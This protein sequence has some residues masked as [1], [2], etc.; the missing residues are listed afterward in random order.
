MPKSKTAKA[1]RPN[2]LLAPLQWVPERLGEAIDTDPSLVRPLLDI[3]RARMHL[4][5]LAL[6]HLTGD[7]SP[8]LARLFLTG[9]NKEI[10]DCCLANYPPGLGRVLG[11]L[12]AKVIAAHSYRWLVDLL[13]DPATRKC[14]HHLPSIDETTI[15]AVHRLPTALRQPA[16][17]AM[18]GQ[19][20]GMARFVDGLTFLAA[21][22]RFPVDS[23]LNDIGTLQQP[24]Q[25][26]AKVRRLVEALPLPNP[27]LPNQIGRF[28]RL[29]SIAEIRGLAK[30]WRNCLEDC[31]AQ[32]NEN[33]AAVYLS[34]QDQVVCLVIRYGR[35]GWAISQVK[36]PKN[37]DVNSDLLAQIY[38]AFSGAGIVAVEDIEAIRWI[39]WTRG[40]HD[41]PLRDMDVEEAFLADPIL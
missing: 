36:G 14:L 17:M 3:S 13:A 34:D 5:A 27:V 16:I 21:R 39:A 9:S 7:V 10:L 1:E 26:A 30:A 4:V 29:D 24:A 20:K 15:T 40:W 11:R 23:F 25:V 31:V 19:V 37:T 12:P 32:I 22:A 6:A 33:T 2:F 8:S 38:S 41:R 28:R 18:V 35:I